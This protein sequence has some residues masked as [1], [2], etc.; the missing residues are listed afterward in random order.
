MAYSHHFSRKERIL[1][2]ACAAL[3]ITFAVV[4]AVLASTSG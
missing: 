3:L 2:V 4:G 1:V